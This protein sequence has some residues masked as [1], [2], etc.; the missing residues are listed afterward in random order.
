L[1]NSCHLLISGY[2]G[3]PTYQQ[4]FGVGG[5][6]PYPQ[7]PPPPAHVQQGVEGTYPQQPP[8]SWLNQPPTYPATEYPTAGPGYPLTPYPPSGPQPYPDPKY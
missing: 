6:N 2:A 5:I 4:D 3:V 7:Q 1:S 8:P